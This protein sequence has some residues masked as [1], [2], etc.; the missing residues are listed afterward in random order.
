MPKPTQKKR[1][2][3]PPPVEQQVNPWLSLAQGIVYQAIVDWKSLDACRPIPGVSYVTIRK[4]L[5]SPW[6]ETLLLFTDI[7]PEAIIEALE[8]HSRE[9]GI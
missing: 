1:L 3:E 9:E 8:R 4:F 2:K 6:C 5:L 7:A